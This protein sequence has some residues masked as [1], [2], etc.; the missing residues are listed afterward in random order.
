[1]HYK[2]IV[3]YLNDLKSSTDQ[4]FEFKERIGNR[5]SYL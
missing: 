5:D 4:S 2:Q 1:M 3:I